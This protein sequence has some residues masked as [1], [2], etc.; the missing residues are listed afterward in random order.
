MTLRKKK[1]DEL[2]STEPCAICHGKYEGKVTIGQKDINALPAKVPAGATMAPEEVR[3][4]R[5]LQTSAWLIERG[6]KHCDAAYCERYDDATLHKLLAW[7]SGET[8]VPDGP[9][10]CDD[11][12]PAA[13]GQAAQQANDATE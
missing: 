13:D 10:P 7:A 5:V 11:P 6:W 9:G 4:Q 8:D 3:R 2:D 1:T 12:V